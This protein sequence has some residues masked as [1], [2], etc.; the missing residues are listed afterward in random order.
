MSHDETI[1][2]VLECMA[3]HRTIR[4]FT[5]EPVPDEHIE[6]AVAAA[7]MAATSSWIQAYSLLQVVD[8]AERAQLAEL[9]GNQAQVAD[10]GAFFVVSAD[11][12][13]HVLVAREAKAERVDNLET[14]LLAV[15]DASLF[16]Q[17]LTLA[18][19]AMGHGTCYIGG[20]RNR[21]P[22]V[23]A[24]L[25]LPEG[26][27]PLFGLCVGSPAGDPGLRPRFAPRAILAR[28]RYPEDEEL[29]RG[30]AEHDAEAASYY[31]DRGNPG[32][33]WSGG[34]WR[35]FQRPMREHL[36]AF[37]RSKGARLD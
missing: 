32:R 20:L 22:E 12:R 35:K 21:L 10:A 27:W 33:N 7:R 14:F 19:E 36:L 17:N 1:E 34:L 8:E 28:G 16:A 5:D 30:V 25:E 18:F 15:I 2:A 13:R 24:L 4:S 37:Y 3:S 9:T 23:D 31:N 26:V 6:R 29:L 11:I